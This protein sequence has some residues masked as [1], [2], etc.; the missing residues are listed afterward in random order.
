MQSGEALGGKDI[1][2]CLKS[3]RGTL[4]IADRVWTRAEMLL[5]EYAMERAAITARHRQLI[6]DWE[7]YKAQKRSQKQKPN[8]GETLEANVASSTSE[9]S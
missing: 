1:I 8:S 5:Q 7:Q 2:G 3:L 4:G 9:P 6:A